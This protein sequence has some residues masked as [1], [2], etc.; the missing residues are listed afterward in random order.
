MISRMLILDPQQRASMSEIQH[1]PWMVKSFNEPP[2]S[3]LP[4]REPLQL[5]LDP[6]LVNKMTEFGFGRPDQIMQE[7]EIILK[8]EDY[9]QW[10]LDFRHRL[11]AERNKPERKC[12]VFKFFKRKIHV[13]HT[14]LTKLCEVYDP[15][16]HPM[17]SIYYL[18]REK[19]ERERRETQN[20]SPVQ[21]GNS[22]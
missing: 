1:H 7:L 16:Y 19:L 4:Y 22:H 5:P 17:I 21:R 12:K 14:R 13:P 15:P 8:S 9:R 11:A 10:A 6:K 20:F 2:A 3:F 18:V